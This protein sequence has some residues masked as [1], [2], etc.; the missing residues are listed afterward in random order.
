MAFFWV[1]RSHPRR[2]HTVGSG[3]FPGYEAPEPGGSTV[4]H[5]EA[6][7]AE[8]LAELDQSN[9]ALAVQIAGLPEGVRGYGHIKESARERWLAEEARLLEEFHRPPAPVLLFDPARKSAA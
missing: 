8:L 5:F 4:G 9:L 6:V 3:F 2:C 1:P 7:V